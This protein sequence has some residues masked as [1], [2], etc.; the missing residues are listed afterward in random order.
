MSQI[1]EIQR[2]EHELVEAMRKSDTVALDCLFA[3]DLLFTGPDGKLVG[4]VADIEAHRSGITRFTHIDIQDTVIK[5]LPG[6]AIAMVL[7]Y[8]EGTYADEPFAGHYRYT[9]IWSNHTG[10]WQITGGHCSQVTD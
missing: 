3:D 5:P 9:R 6:V 2:V 4:K 8:L 10:Q 1:T 7:T